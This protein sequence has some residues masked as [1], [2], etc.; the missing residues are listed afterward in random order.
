VTQ[1]SETVGWNQN[2]DEAKCGNTRTCNEVSF[3]LI[4]KVSHN[5]D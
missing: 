5:F 1:C 4:K 2:G 3:I